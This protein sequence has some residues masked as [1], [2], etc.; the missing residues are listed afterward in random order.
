MQTGGRMEKQEMVMSV[1]PENRRGGTAAGLC[2][3]VCSPYYVCSPFL[4]QRQV[5]SSNSH[6]SK[7]HLLATPT[8]MSP[9]LGCLHHR[10]PPLPK[11]CPPYSQAFQLPLPT[12][13]PNSPSSDM[14][15]GS[16]RPEGETLLKEAGRG[17]REREHPPVEGFSSSWGLVCLTT[18]A[19]LLSHC[20]LKM[21]WHL[22]L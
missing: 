12:P 18:W 14:E 20:Y 22:S 1:A 3:G 21:Q 5:G 13:E 17:W 2:P 11:R 16:Q 8:Q 4:H 10:L 6:P 19:S 15:R 9:E 7:G